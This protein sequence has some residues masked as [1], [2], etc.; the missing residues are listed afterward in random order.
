MKKAPTPKNDNYKNKAWLKKRYLVDKKTV[1][2]IG[3]ECG[4]SYQTIYNW[5]VR[6]ELIRNGRTWK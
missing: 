3:N 5:L 6:F 2:A 1:T 4:V